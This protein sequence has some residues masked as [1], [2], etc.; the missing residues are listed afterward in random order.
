MRANVL[1]MSVRMLGV[2][3]NVG[4]RIDFM[5]PLFAE[6]QAVT[7][8]APTRQG[9]HLGGQRP[10]V[11]SNVAPRRCIAFDRGQ[12]RLVR[13]SGYP[14]A[15]PAGAAR[16]RDPERIESLRLLLRQAC[17]PLTHPSGRR[18]AANEPPF[19]DLNLPPPSRGP[20][21]AAL[22]STAPSSDA[23]CSISGVSLDLSQYATAL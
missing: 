16:F 23:S 10:R 17:V 20:G 7:P 4:S 9:G 6:G 12:D 21:S 5:S 13:R 2:Y 1:L 14:S 11:H 19:D 15:S 22:E 8:E 3:R 18:H